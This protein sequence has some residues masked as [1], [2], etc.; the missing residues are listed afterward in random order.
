MGARLF[1]HLVRLP[2]SFFEK[3]HIGDVLSRFNSIEPIRNALAEG[4][5]L[6]V[7]DGIMALATLAMIFIYSA[8]LALVV[9]PALLLYL[10]VRLALYRRFRDLSEATIQAAAMENSN[11]IETARAIQ[12]VKLFNREADRESQWLNRHADTVNANIRQGRAQIQFRTIN[13]GIF[14]LENIVTVYLAAMLAL[15]IR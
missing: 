9:V 6:A 1:H 11:F 12:S 13:A 8:Q 4:M 10:I 15:D 5:I 7:I 2:L 3:R 14:G